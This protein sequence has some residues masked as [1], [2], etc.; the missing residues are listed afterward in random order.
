MAFGI[1]VFTTSGEE[2]PLFSAQLIYAQLV[3]IAA[4]ASMV[5]PLPVAVDQ[6][7]HWFLKDANMVCD[8][9]YVDG[10]ASVTVI[11]RDSAA[12]NF[13]IMMLRI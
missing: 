9:D 5:I 6:T 2:V 4:N 12:T 11:N 10:E 1:E 13:R 8:L 7:Q 3:S